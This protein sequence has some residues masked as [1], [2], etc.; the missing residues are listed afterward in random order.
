M[1]NMTSSQLIFDNP[2]LDSILKQ[3]SEDAMKKL[4]VL[5]KSKINQV[6]QSNLNN[7]EENHDQNIQYFLDK[8]QVK[9]AD[10]A[11]DIALNDDF[12][13][14]YFKDQ[15]GKMIPS[16]F[17]TPNAF[18]LPES[19]S[20]TEDHTYI[21]NDK[22]LISLINYR[23]IE[24]ER[25]NLFN[26]FTFNKWLMAYIVIKNEKI[27]KNKKV[28]YNE[29]MDFFNEYVISQSIVANKD[30]IIICEILN[31]KFLDFLT[32]LSIKVI[33]S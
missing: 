29:L 30:F 11:K 15:Y 28:V 12:T 26:K 5:Q 1:K 20:F 4:E 3:A 33:S 6:K 23:K 25:D 24:I 19:Q 21:I 10:N 18:S 32:I 14:K 13:Q 17:K 31:A 2:L 8:N 16:N 27:S 7:R 22:D 9:M